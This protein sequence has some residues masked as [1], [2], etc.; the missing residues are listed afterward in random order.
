MNPEPEPEGPPPIMS[1]SASRGPSKGPSKGVVIVAAVC[2][3]AAYF[4]FKSD[5]DWGGDMGRESIGEMFSNFHLPS[6]G[7]GIMHR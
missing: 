5:S 2:I 3:A 7:G 1:R 6:S 4:F